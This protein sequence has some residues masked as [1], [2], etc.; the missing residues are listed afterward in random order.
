MEIPVWVIKHEESAESINP[1]CLLWFT[2]LGI[3]VTQ[4]YNNVRYYL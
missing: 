3:N 1:I 2:S 4:V